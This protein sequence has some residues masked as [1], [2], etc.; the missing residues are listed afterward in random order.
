MLG[1]RK[2]KRSNEE[3]WFDTKDNA[4]RSRLKKPTQ[5]TS[6]K[7]SGKKWKTQFAIPQAVTLKIPRVH[8]PK[9]ITIRFTKPKIFKK[10]WLQK[11]V[12]NTWKFC[13]Q[14]KTITITAAIFFII[15]TVIIVVTS[16]SKKQQSSTTQTVQ[17]AEKPK[18][19]FEP[20]LSLEKQAKGG[21]LGIKYSP[22]KKTASAQDNY[23]EK[24]ITLSQQQITKE[25]AKDP[26][27]IEK[28]ANSIAQAFSLPITARKS[29]N[30]N[31]GIL[32]YFDIPDSTMQRGVMVFKELLVFFVTDQQL[33]TDDWQQYLKSLSPVTQ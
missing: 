13:S 20:V 14:Y 24:T 25:Q 32:Y 1:Q 19:E 18:P 6:L 9:T 26:T 33:D 27:T 8:I 17:E 29:V 11:V 31:A 30:S 28:A 15:L 12:K 5:T 3:N 7:K 16:P 2:V 4:L 23:F 22:D 21:D 10:H